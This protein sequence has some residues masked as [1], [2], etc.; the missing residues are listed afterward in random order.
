[1]TEFRDQEV[2]SLRN[3]GVGSIIIGLI[4]AS[5]GFIALHN[6][7]GVVPLLFC[8]M[9]LVIFI[10]GMKNIID[11]RKLYR[12]KLKE[13]TLDTTAIIRSSPIRK[14]LGLGAC[15]LGTT[16]ILLIIFLLR[17][18]LGD[19]SP[20]E[21]GGVFWRL[22]GFLT[23]A[24]LLGI[25]SFALVPVALLWW[26]IIVLRPTTLKQAVNDLHSEDH[27]KR[28]EAVTRL[29]SINWIPTT[30]IDHI[31]FLMA[32]DFW[33]QVVDSGDI[34]IKRALETLAWEGPQPGK[35]SALGKSSSP[36]AIKALIKFLADRKNSDDNEDIINAL[37][38]LTGK[39]FGDNKEQW[40]NW[41][42]HHG[43]QNTN[44]IS[45]NNN[46]VE[47]RTTDES[48]VILAKDAQ[49]ILKKP[50]DAALKQCPGCAEKIKLD[51][52]VCEFCGHE[53]NGIELNE[54]VSRLETEK[55]EKKLN[56]GMHTAFEEKRNKKKK[57]YRAINIYGGVAKILWT[58]GGILLF[59][60]TMK[61]IRELDTW[62]FFFYLFLIL[63]LF[64]SPAA[65]LSK[66][67]AR[68]RNQMS[69]LD[70]EISQLTTESAKSENN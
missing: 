16:G 51:A 58:T 34:G 15:I 28:K 9:G 32:Q 43:N 7:G 64:A 14:A 70:E 61:A 47:D 48:T 18:L 25:L 27:I 62:I 69:V 10:L 12:R 59:I 66:K 6:V 38:E 57:L 1:M 26:G 49:S 13:G 56:P 42:E 29:T 21:A 20:A 54:K 50:I 44:N 30:E 17:I 40:I 33:Q 63:L 52:T 60:T 11:S 55:V 19:M 46:P 24:G 31:D 65:F 4:G 68:K 22:F 36:L 5:A 2:I 35:F 67:A 39:N 3:F 45:E 8:L 41:Y 37:Q 23:G 53:F